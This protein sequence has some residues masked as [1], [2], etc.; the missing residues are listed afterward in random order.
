MEMISRSRS[1]A[2]LF[3]AAA[4]AACASTQPL[5]QQRAPGALPPPANAGAAADPA[6]A[7]GA[8]GRPIPRPI[9]TP[10]PP[11]RQGDVQVRPER[12]APPPGDVRTASERADDIAAWDRCV[13]RAQGAFENPGSA[14]PVAASPEE[15]CRSRL[16]MSDRLAVPQSRLNK[17][18]R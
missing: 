1:L 12:P 15:Y 8:A 13:I 18:P 9:P 3:A 7:P 2:A 5:P 4:L 16:G 10:P 11:I 17:S 14:N 6:P